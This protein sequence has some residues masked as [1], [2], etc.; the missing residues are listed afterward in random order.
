MKALIPLTLFALALAGCGQFSSAGAPMLNPPRAAGESSAMFREVQIQKAQADKFVVYR[1]AWIG[2]STRLGPAGM[3]Q[4]DRIAQAL[5]TRQETVIVEEALGE[6][7]LNA[8]RKAAVAQAL[9]ERGLPRDQAD[10]LVVVGES[11]ALGLQSPDVPIIQKGL[12][13]P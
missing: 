2:N 11:R 9:A 5:L 12:E 6:D 8:A 13:K 7:D 4:L 10:S 1:Q 3:R